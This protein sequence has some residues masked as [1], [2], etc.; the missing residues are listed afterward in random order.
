MGFWFVYLFC[1]AGDQARAFFM[2]VRHVLYHRA[3]H[4]ARCGCCLNSL[5]VAVTPKWDLRPQMALSSFPKLQNMFY[6]CYPR[7]C[8]TNFIFIN[9][10]DSTRLFT[11]TNLYAFSSHRRFIISLCTYC[12]N[13]IA[14]LNGT[15]MFCTLRHWCCWLSTVCLTLLHCSY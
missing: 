15:I 7:S 1:G 5:V 8:T 10:I 2:H 13:W 3:T 9:F 4:P 6:I 11:S 12:S 14:Y